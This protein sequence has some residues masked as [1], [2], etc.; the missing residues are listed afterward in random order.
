[1]VHP[2]IDAVFQAGRN[3]GDRLFTKLPVAESIGW[4][5]KIKDHLTPEDWK[6][7]DREITEQLSQENDRGVAITCAAMI[8]D[9]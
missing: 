4:D 9:R 1:M 5:G 8:D 7:L 2:W 3:F 6:S